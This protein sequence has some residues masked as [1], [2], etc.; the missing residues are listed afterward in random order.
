MN[1]SHGLPEYLSDIASLEVYIKSECNIESI[2]Y[3][4]TTELAGSIRWSL[5]PNLKR[6]GQQFGRDTPM[7]A[8]ELT[9]LNQADLQLFSQHR[10]FTLPSGREVGMDDVYLSAN[11]QEDG[12]AYNI[13]EGLGVRLDMAVSESG[14]ASGNA[15]QLAN[16]IQKARKR[17]G[18]DSSA[19]LRAVLLADTEQDQEWL[20][21]LIESHGD[22]ILSILRAM[23]RVAT[24][25]QG[26]AATNT[27]TIADR[28][29][30]ARF[31]S[32]WQ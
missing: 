21:A 26:K 3:V 8:Q 11:A 1:I 2:Q 4:S 5:Q 10:R 7:V 30:Y 25:Q 29:F 6:L 23:P 22:L 27:I 16:E 28:R 12:A 15:R 32:D 18:L 17:C 13:D 31:E 14:Q 19:Q 24:Q 20:A 9:T